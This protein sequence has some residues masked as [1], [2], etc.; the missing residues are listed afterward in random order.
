MQIIGLATGY[1]VILQWVGWLFQ[2]AFAWPINHVP[3]FFLVHLSAIEY[4]V[5]VAG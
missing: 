2:T 4:G 1:A 5:A 3:F